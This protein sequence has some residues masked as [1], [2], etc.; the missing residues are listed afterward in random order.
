MKLTTEDEIIR[1]KTHIYKKSPFFS[2]ILLHMKMIE[3]KDE[4]FPPDNKTMSVDVNGTIRWHKDFVEKLSHEQL[5]GVITHECCH[6][7]L[8]HLERGERK[9]HQI[10]NIA[11]DLVINDMLLEDGFSLPKEG[12]LPSNHT[13]KIFDTEIERIN[14]K[15][16]EEIYDE[17]YPLFP[18]IKSVL[19]LL[20]AS[21]D[22]KGTGKGM[23][24]DDKENAKKMKGFDKHIYGKP[25]NGDEE[26]KEGEN[27]KFDR[28][29]KWK[30]IIAEATQVARQQ[31]RLPAGIERRVEEVLDSKVDWKHKLYKYV[32]AQ[33]P[34]DFS[35]SNPSKRGASLGIYLPKVLKESVQIVVSIDT[36]GSI[37]QTDLQEF[38]SELISIGNSFQNI[39]LEIIV[40]DAEIHETYEL[41]RDNVDDILSMPLSGGGGTSHEPIL[42]YIEKNIQD[43]KCLLNFTDGYT[44]FGEEP[45]YDVVWVLCKGG[46]PTENIPYGEVIKIE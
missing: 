20:S 7:A 28:S 15:S 8:L 31:G 45:N 40:C 5:M 25:N 3:G 6:I 35:W 17:L 23:S 37:S 11:N 34:H 38:L 24:P 21:G 32:V 27:I 18:K 41:T 10:S 19:N 30:K 12:C 39:K 29:Q 22:G 13:W 2:Y 9:E 1:A 16:S 46:C 42:K 4:D 26:N 43:A 14:E 33:I 36:S 44:G